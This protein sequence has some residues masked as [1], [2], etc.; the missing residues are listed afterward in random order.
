MNKILVV[1]DEKNLLKL[2]TSELEDEGYSVI[3]LNNGKDVLKNIKASEPQV[4][5][6][7]I[8]L[9]DIEGLEVLEQIK[10]Y[11]LNL[12]VILNT[13]YSTYKANF[14][15]WIADEYVLKSPD[16]TELKSAIKKYVNIN[17]SL[18]EQ[19]C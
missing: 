3:P 2:Y 12:P 1:E 14:S 9:D 7:D 16:L 4:V 15:T 11:D 6:L 10:N 18:Q 13:A 8:L 5:V 17:E 19:G